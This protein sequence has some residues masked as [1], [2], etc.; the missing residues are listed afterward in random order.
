[1]FGSKWFLM[2]RRLISRLAA[3]D[4][5]SI[6]HSTTARCRRQQLPS[7][8]LPSDHNSSHHVVCSAGSRLLAAVLLLSQIPRL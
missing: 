6:T 2:C 1:M 3:F 7:V 5:C 4:L 8:M